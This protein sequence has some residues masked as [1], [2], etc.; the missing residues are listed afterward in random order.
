MTSD[1]E[2]TYL[3]SKKQVTYIESDTGDGHIIYHVLLQMD[4]DTETLL[5]KDYYVQ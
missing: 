1:T 5:V 3:K 2:K 4:S